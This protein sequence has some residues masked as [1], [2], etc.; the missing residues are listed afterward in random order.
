MINEKKQPMEIDELKELLTYY[1]EAIN[2]EYIQIDVMFVRKTSNPKRL[3]KTWM[4]VCRNQDITDMVKETLDNMITKCEERHIDNYD[5]ELST[6]D[7]IQVVEEKKV[8]NYPQLINSLSINYTEENTVNDKIDYNEF[9]YVIIKVS[10]NSEE[11]AKSSITLLKKHFRSPA[12]FKGTKS[13]IF[14]GN[15]AEVFNKRLLIVGS[16]IEAVNVEQFFYIVNRDVFNTML[17]FKDLY[18]K[19]VDE[20]TEEI[21]QA[22][23]FDNTDEFI[24]NCRNDGRYV[25]RLTKAILV[26]SFKNVKANKEKLK[27][28]KVDYGLNLEFTEDGKIVYKKEHI[29]EILNLLLEHYVTSALTNKKMLAKAIEK[30]NS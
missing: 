4:L 1:A 10:D 29:S 8:L 3:Y 30:Y 15:Q 13:F 24:T 2:E 5:L 27:S 17:N 12:K 21:K 20:N 22:D 11:E 7:T 16:N 26:E 6:D 14:N 18:Y 23:L 9:G 19:I 25:T 28:I